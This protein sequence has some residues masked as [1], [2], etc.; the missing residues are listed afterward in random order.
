MKRTPLLLMLSPLVFANA[1][2]LERQEQESQSVV[3]AHN[4]M[5]L[6]TSMT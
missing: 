6:V 2:W 1:S 5:V 4:F 3:T